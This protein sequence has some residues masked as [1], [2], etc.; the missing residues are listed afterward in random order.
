MKTTLRSSHGAERDVR[1][2][3]ARALAEDLGSGDITTAACVPVDARARGRFVA[4][5]ELM[6]AGVELLPLIYEQEVETRYASGARIAAGEVIAAVAGPA[7]RL[8]ERERV[9]LNFLQH[10]SGVATHTRRFVDAVAGTG[11][12]ILDT[13]KT[14]PGLRRLEKQAVAAGGGSNHRMGLYDAV[15]IKENHVAAAGGIR[16]AV[17][18]ARRA[19]KGIEVEV[20]N[21]EEMEEALAAGATRVLLDNMT[22]EQVRACVALARQTVGAGLAP[23]EGAASPG[24]GPARGSARTE[25]EPRTRASSA[26]TNKPGS[27]PPQR[28]LVEVSGGVTLANVRDYAL[29]GPD[30]ISVGALTHSAPAADI[31][32]LLVP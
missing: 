3:I 7:R 29:A 4:R 13:R 26:P 25:R 27:P 6:L 15:L 1:E 19:A 31:S 2:L 20:R 17:A 32:F 24:P 23:P 18:A 9:A 28:V 11:V 22:P 14:L 5:Q 30:F 10:L 12:T 16:A 21:R 8:L